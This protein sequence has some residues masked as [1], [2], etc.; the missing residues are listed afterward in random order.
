MYLDGCR[1][2][3]KRN[4]SHIYMDILLNLNHDVVLSDIVVLF[5]YYFNLS[6]IL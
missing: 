6:G 4:F 5:E 1:P 3:R 2:M